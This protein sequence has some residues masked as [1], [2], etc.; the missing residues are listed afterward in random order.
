MVSLGLMKSS[1]VDQEEIYLEIKNF[2]SKLSKIVD[3][4]QAE[5]NTAFLMDGSPRTSS[6]LLTS[7][8]AYTPS[9]RLENVVKQIVQEDVLEAEK[10]SASASIF[11]IKFLNE[12]LDE[13]II[14]HTTREK[15]EKRF[16]D[17]TSHL[18]SLM[19]RPVRKDLEKFLNKNFPKKVS[20][21]VIK[22]LDLAGPSGKIKFE[23]GNIPKTIISSDSSHEFNVQ[24]DENIMIMNNF[25]WKRKGVS[26]VCIEGFIEKVSEIDCILSTATD[27]KKPLVIF[28]L[29]Y[30]QEV[31]STIVLNN[32]RGTF[33]IMLVSPNPEADSINDLGDIAAVTC[34]QFLSYQQGSI[35]T[36]FEKESLEEIC[37]EISINNEIIH[38]K[39]S[40]KSAVLQ[41]RINSVREK[42]S[43]ADAFEHAQEDYLRKRLFSL[44]GNQVTVFIPEGS[45]QK[46]F[47]DIE[48][49]DSAL[50]C[51]RAI[52]N[53][54]TVKL[55]KED[56]FHMVGNQIASAI[57]VG[58]T[59]AYKLTMQLSN[60]EKCII[61]DD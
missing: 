18:Q 26:V 27:L 10:M 35:S 3:A 54:G 44:T 36:S 11:L 1:V 29:G 43:V 33:D 21:P 9:S 32:K 40:K 34:S 42:L 59:K 8:L 30:S 49:M 24:P 13:K 47:K 4:H 53:Y 23:H 46:K 56:G 48:E 6:S 16:K 45:S 19:R 39:K 37:D 2:L 57:Y 14:K 60:M 25:S 31:I 15:M 58:M 41:G 5:K 17:K 28:C 12:F 22:A 7:L 38:I 20:K 50:R 55:K 51:S 61:F 52:I